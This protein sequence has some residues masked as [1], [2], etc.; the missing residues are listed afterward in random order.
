MSYALSHHIAPAMV[1]R[2]MGITFFPS[3]ICPLLY[4]AQVVYS[5][6]RKAAPAVFSGSVTDKWAARS[7]ELP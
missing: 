3:S 7:P 1:P 6:L 4:S 2:R 5:P